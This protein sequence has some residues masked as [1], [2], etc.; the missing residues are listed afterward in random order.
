MRLL[1]PKTPAP[2]GKI[3][4]DTVAARASYRPVYKRIAPEDARA[5]DAPAHPE[6]HAP[7]TA[8]ILTENPATLPEASPR[9]NAA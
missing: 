8:E 2:R 9:V 3:E 5:T 6:R 7:G 4:V 1:D